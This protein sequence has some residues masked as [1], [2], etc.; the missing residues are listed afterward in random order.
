M[1]KTLA[2][3]GERNAITRLSKIITK[4]ND[5]FPIGDDCAILPVHDEYMLVSTDMVAQHT[6]LSSKMTPWQIG[7]FLVAVNLSDLAAK[8]GIPYG[9]VLALG[10]PRSYPVVSFE[11]LIHGAHDCAQAFNTRILGGDTKESKEL[12]LTGTVLG[13]V[14]KNEFMGRK[15][16][17]IS[18][19]IAVTGEIGKA[20]AGMYVLE[21]DILSE[22]ACLHFLFEPQPRITAGR[23]LA[24]S[25]RIHCCMDT[26]DGI[27]T[28]LYQ[29]QE[30]NS[31][32]FCI[33]SSLLPISSACSKL[34]VKESE[35][36]IEEYVLQG[37]GDYE[38]LCTLHP[39]DFSMIKSQLERIDVSFTQIGV[40]TKEKEIVYR[41]NGKKKT[42][43]NKGY[44]H[45]TS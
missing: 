32:G 36:N 2:D 1:M 16:A 8:G 29:L 20:A 39:D 30:I 41:K 14:K 9:L 42:L 34:F 26:S 19:V 43:R 18:D 27:S 23:I 4:K 11:E 6:H 35:Q 13:W 21:K 17:K 28:S 7:W 10:L 40:V 25:G 15:G 12:V 22:Q 38:L 24:Q 3:I 45:F 33:D 37:G 5:S 44:E 31:V